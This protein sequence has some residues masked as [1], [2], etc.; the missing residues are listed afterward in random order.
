[1]AI[2]DFVREIIAVALGDNL[3]EILIGA[4]KKKPSGVAAA[5]PTAAELLKKK[6]EEEKFDRDKFLT[7]LL[8]MNRKMHGALQNILDL[9]VEF[10]KLGGVISIGKRKS[11]K[12]YRENWTGAML[13]Q[14]ELADRA[15]VWPM[16]DNMLAR[17]RGEFF[18]Y[19]EIMHDDN[20]LQIE[21]QLKLEFENTEVGL[22]AKHLEKE[23]GKIGK[24]LSGLTAKPKGAAHAG[25][26][27][28]LEAWSKKYAGL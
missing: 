26:V 28:E 1:M 24:S 2:G 12:T 7:I 4:E 22:A 25:P 23:L 14:F 6:M 13:Q 20:I 15:W 10:Q 8:T 11:M 19:L 9:F 21:R 3:G 27:E 16:L 17:D 18:A 5:I